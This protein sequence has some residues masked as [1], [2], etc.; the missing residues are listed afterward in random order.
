MQLAKEANMTLGAFIGHV[1]NG[2]VNEIAS[3]VQDSRN[4]TEAVQKLEAIRK[5][6]NS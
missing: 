6:V 1:L 4:N 3:I 2:A 5:I